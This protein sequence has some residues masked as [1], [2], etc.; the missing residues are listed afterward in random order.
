MPQM[1]MPSRRT[2]I[3]S[4][5]QEATPQTGVRFE[6]TYSQAAEVSHFHAQQTSSGERTKPET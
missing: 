5:T 6:R 2:S 1:S 4:L 3:S